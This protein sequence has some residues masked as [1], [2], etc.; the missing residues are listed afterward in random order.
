M[1]CIVQ[2]HLSVSINDTAI[3][4]FWGALITI[5]PV[6]L[7]QICLCAVGFRP[8]V[9]YS[10]IN[11]IDGHLVEALAKRFVK[12]DHIVDTDH[13]PTADL[14]IGRCIDQAVQGVLFSAECC[15]RDDDYPQNPLRMV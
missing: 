15:P 8:G 1:S 14:V 4:F 9:R 10:G 5:T 2:S 6:R 11:D 13:L 12:S 7:S 3:C